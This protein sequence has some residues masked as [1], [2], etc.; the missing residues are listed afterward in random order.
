MRIQRSKRGVA[1]LELV[2]CMPII[3]ALMVA[4]VWLGSS[5]V[6]QSQVAIE[7]RRDAW[8]R[9]FEAGSSKALDFLADDFTTATATTEVKVG[10]LVDDASP[11]ESSHD[12]AV[13]VWDH[14]TIR[15]NES[16]NWELYLTAAINAKTAGLQVAY[17]DARNQISQLQGQ[18]GQAVVG[19]IQNAIREELE[20]PL[21]QLKNIF[22]NL[23]A[24][25]E[26]QADQQRQKFDRDIQA[27]RREIEQVESRIRELER[28]R[29]QAEGEDAKKSLEA[30]P[31][32]T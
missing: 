16:P 28:A 20:S 27:K 14:A 15:M 21:S 32:A 5:V 2:M 3:L 19:E 30:R 9:R 24:S 4:L 12:V 17:S 8:Q 29:D 13:N 6:G 10:N 25:T 1:T 22:G 18:A 31:R 23:N 11:P 26:S 7:A